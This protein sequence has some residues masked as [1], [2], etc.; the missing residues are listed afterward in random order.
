MAHA[1]GMVSILSSSMRCLS[2]V[3]MG[4]PMNWAI[5]SDRRGELGV[6]GDRLLRVVA[7]VAHDDLELA[8]ADAAGGVDLLEVELLGLGELLPREA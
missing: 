6:G 5:A 7:V 8:A 3:T 1:S 4:E 2:A